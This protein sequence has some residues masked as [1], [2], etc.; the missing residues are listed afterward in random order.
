MASSWMVTIACLFI[1]DIFIVKD[2]RNYSAQSLI[3]KYVE[4]SFYKDY[5]SSMTLNIRIL[6][7]R[8][9]TSTFF[10]H[11][12]DK[13]SQSIWHP[14]SMASHIKMSFGREQRK[15][16]Y[17]FSRLFWK[18]S[19]YSK[20]FPG[21]AVRDSCVLIYARDKKVFSSDKRCHSISLHFSPC[22]G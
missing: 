15:I 20:S 14:P 17:F 13:I 8:M 16:V 22:A 10:I 19:S 5:F 9:N 18:V 7:C 6:N 3:K 21:R 4:S 2:R 11:F 12:N 1:R